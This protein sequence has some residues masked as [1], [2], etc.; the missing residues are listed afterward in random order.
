MYTFKIVITERYVLE[1]QYTTLIVTKTYYIGKYNY[2]K[3]VTNT[4][5]P[6]STLPNIYIYIWPKK[7]ICVF[8]VTCQKNLGS[9]GH[10][11]KIVITERYVLELQ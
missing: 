2:H 1:L 10:T 6:P 7:N 11:F 5:Y 3:I 8:T 4:S 9:V